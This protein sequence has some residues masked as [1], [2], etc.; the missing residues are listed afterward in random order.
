MVNEVGK[1]CLISYQANQI[2]E[3]TILEVNNQTMHELASILATGH[4]RWLIRWEA[5]NYDELQPIHLPPSL[6]HITARLTD[7][8]M[9]CLTDSAVAFERLRQVIGDLLG[10]DAL[11]TKWYNTSIPGNHLSE[12][13]LWLLDDHHPSDARPFS[14]QYFG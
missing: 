11:R 4:Q 9:A 12:A 1:T 8:R 6:Q 5:R 13:R 3:I 7:F 14:Y 2:V 10:I